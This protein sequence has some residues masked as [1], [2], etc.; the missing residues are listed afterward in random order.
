M[1]QV[2]LSL[3]VR[4][5]VKVQEGYEKTVVGVTKCKLEGMTSEKEVRSEIRVD[6]ESSDGG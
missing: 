2:E 1:S 3:E 4:G 5:G 6:T